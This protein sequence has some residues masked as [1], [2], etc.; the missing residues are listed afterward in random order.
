[1]QN[2]R[3][4][5]SM[6]ESFAKLEEVK[7]ECDQIDEETS[8]ILEEIK[9]IPDKISQTSK[10]ISNIPR[11]AT[12]PSIITKDLKQTAED[13]TF[14]VSTTQN[15]MEKLSKIYNE[16]IQINT[17]NFYFICLIFGV[18]NVLSLLLGLN[19]EFPNEN[20]RK[21]VSFKTKVSF[22]LSLLV[23]VF[24][25][26]LPR[27]TREKH[28]IAVMIFL[29]NFS[30]FLANS[31]VIHYIFFGDCPFSEVPHGVLF[32][33]DMR[34]LNLT[35]ILLYFRYEVK[36]MLVLVNL[37]VFSLFVSL[38]S[39]I[40]F[41]L[42][43]WKN[44][45]DFLAFLFSIALIILFAAIASWKNYYIKDEKKKKRETIEEE[46][47]KIKDELE[48]VKKKLEKTFKTVSRPE[49][50]SKADEL[51]MKLKYLKFQA[52][53]NLKNKM[54]PS[55]NSGKRKMKRG[56]NFVITDSCGS[57][58]PSKMASAGNVGDNQQSIF[59]FFFWFFLSVSFF[60]FFYLF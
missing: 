1:M 29:F 36:S 33:K 28:F 41:Q 56:S 43:L 39:L 52:L 32:E 46:A 8:K 37:L 2:I 34:V 40:F 26:A 23:F 4:A 7:E 19:S 14:E 58:S 5:K 12:V 47:K 49:T 54:S 51:L 38:Y 55:P 3:H 21:L 17:I 15:F 59:M 22:S 25:R 13:L 50:A 60:K 42:G 6:S 44:I 11:T 9:E 48:S 24:F 18:F 31:L 53:V 57:F 16:K 20:T 10:E 35:V 45:E 27:R 30:T